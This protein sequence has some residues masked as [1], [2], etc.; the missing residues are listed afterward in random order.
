MGGGGEGGGGRGTRKPFIISENN[1]PRVQTPI[2][3]IPVFE[4]HSSWAKINPTRYLKGLSQEIEILNK[5]TAI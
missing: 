5:Q 4:T 2:S 3:L 1:Q